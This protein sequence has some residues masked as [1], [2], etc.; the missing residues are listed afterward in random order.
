MW[1]DVRDLECV[2]GDVAAF[3]G[4]HFVVDLTSRAPKRRITEALSGKIPTTSVRRLSSRLRRSMGL[5]D[6]I[7]DQCAG[8][9]AV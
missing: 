3:G 7:L 1:V 5:F 2:I 8:G 6:Q 4:D 9:N